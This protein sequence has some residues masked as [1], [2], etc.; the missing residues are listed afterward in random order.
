MN[1]RIQQLAIQARRHFPKT[2]SS[3]EYSV[4]DEQKFAELIVRECVNCAEREIIRNGDTEHNRAIHEV[5]D[6][7]KKHFGVSE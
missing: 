4:F 7:I 3:G 2:E 5:I 6:S 1:E